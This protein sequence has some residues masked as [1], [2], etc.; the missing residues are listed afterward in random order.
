MFKIQLMIQLGCLFE[1]SRPNIYS[2]YCN[3]V[4]IAYPC[5][6]EARADGGV[7]GHTEAALWLLH[8][9]RVVGGDA[10]R[11]SWAERQH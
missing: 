10:H 5:V 2:I 7:D 4:H 8:V 9:Q 3:I 6:A 1:V 11:S